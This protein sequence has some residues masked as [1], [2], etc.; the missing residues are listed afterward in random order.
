MGSWNF[1]T[2]PC[3]I[4]INGNSWG[5]A[6]NLVSFIQSVS[7]I[8]MCFVILASV[9]LLFCAGFKKI[10][11]HVTEECTGQGRNSAEF[12]LSLVV[13]TRMMLQDV[14]VFICIQV[15]CNGLTCNF[16]N[17]SLFLLIISTLNIPRIFLDVFSHF[18]ETTVGVFFFAR[19]STVTAGDV[20]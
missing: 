7:Y 19:G 3:W 4:R 20:P 11:V 5:L 2:I 9:V 13:L 8:N 18:I 16:A 14:F 10:P 17:S 1:G 12:A 15:H 6:G